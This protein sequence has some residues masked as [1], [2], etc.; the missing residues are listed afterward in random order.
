MVQFLSFTTIDELKLFSVFNKHVSH[1]FQVSLQCFV[2]Y[3]YLNLFQRIFCE[4]KGKMFIENRKQFQI[5]S[6]RK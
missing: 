4:K 5:I 6:G 1:R 3:D 2:L